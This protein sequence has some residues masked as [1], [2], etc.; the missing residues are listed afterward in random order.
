MRRRG[1]GGRGI[2]D[3]RGKACVCYKQNIA[4]R[5]QKRAGWRAAA[6]SQRAALAAPFLAT[7]R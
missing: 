5:L 2:S 1:E 6:R 7:D 4:D 3:R